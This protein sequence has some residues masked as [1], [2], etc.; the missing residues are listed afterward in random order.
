MHRQ[1]HR[2]IEVGHWKLDLCKPCSG[3]TTYKKPCYSG[4]RVAKFL[5]LT[6]W[7]RLIELQSHFE[8]AA[9]YI[10]YSERRVDAP[11]LFNIFK[12][13]EPSQDLQEQAG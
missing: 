5:L 11:E 12:G 8:L 1:F 6:K 7:Q 3:P 10:Q 4:Y 13:L 9:D 2:R